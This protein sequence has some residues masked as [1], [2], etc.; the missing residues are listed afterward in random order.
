MWKR[1]DD[2]SLSDRHAGVSLEAVG[3]WAYLLG[4][5]DTKGRFHADARII[6]AKCATFRENLDVET[7]R[8]LLSELARV[9]LIHFY[10]ADGK[11]YFVLHRSAKFNPP[12]AL[13]YAAP[14]FPPP[15][16]SICKCLVE[17]ET[18]WRESDQ[19]RAL[20]PSPSSLPSSSTSSGGIE[21]TLWGY[22]RAQRDAAPISREKGEQQIRLALAAGTKA[23]EIEKAFM[24]SARCAGKKIWE[25]LDPLKP[26]ADPA[27]AMALEIDRREKEKKGAARA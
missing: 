23:S 18:E 7:I 17:G 11:A 8:R 27:R 2:L 5:T 22:W 12:G 25:V 24:D 1:L 6:K 4:H 9:G 26:K 20:V 16:E 3:L 14:S 13:R 10:D 15:P 19:N 21:T